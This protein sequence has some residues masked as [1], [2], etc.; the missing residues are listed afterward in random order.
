MSK[1]AASR[2]KLLSLGTLAG[3][4]AAIIVLDAALEKTDDMAEYVNVRC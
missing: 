2:T 4:F 3:G 1:P